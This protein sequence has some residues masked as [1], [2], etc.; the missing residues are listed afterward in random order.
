MLR[1]AIEYS[2]VCDTSVAS[3]QT[4]VAKIAGGRDCDAGLFMAIG[5]GH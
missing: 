2:A 5:N 3:P 1:L 4:G